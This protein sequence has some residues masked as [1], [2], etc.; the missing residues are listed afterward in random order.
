LKTPEP[1]KDPEFNVKNI[2]RLRMRKRRYAQILV[3]TND[4]VK[5]YKKTHPGCTTKSAKS[6]TKLYYK[7]PEVQSDI[8][9]LLNKNGITLS[10]LNRHLK[11][12]LDD[13]KKEVL[14]KDGAIVKLK[15]NTTKLSALA[16]GYKL[17]GVGEKNSVTVQD[18]R[19]ITFNAS[20]I[21]AEEVEGR[22]KEIFGRLTDLNKQVK[23]EKFITGEIDDPEG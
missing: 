4:P 16:L 6:A 7:N 17:H 3:K 11:E 10:A 14:S 23:E 1:I 22:L 13:P 8:R 18:N 2:T 12:I 5:A 21:P 20:G 9:E 19:S 15:D